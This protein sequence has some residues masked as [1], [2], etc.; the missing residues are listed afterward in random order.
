ML[1]ALLWTGLGVLFLL[2]N[3]GIIPDV[4]TL[5]KRYWPILL[6]FLGAGKVADYFFRK[7]SMS[8]RFGEFSGLVIILQPETSEIAHK[9]NVNKEGR[10]AIRV[11]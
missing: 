6:I 9:L 4:W 7:S 5:T 1:S 3:F 10:Y 8:I 11:R 2:S